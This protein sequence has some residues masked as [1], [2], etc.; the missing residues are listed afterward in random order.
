MIKTLIS[1]YKPIIA[2]VFVSLS[3]TL[4]SNPSAMLFMG[5]FLTLLS[6]LKLMDLNSFAKSFS[7]Y[8]LITKHF[9][10][11]GFIYPFL[12]LFSGLSTIALTNT[13]VSRNT[14]LELIFNQPQIIGFIIFAIGLVGSVSVIKAVYFDKVNFKCACVGGNSKVPLG[15]VSLL[16]N[17]SMAVMGLYL[18]LD[19]QMMI[20]L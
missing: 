5:Y 20:S 18:L 2:L 9:L 14:L 15:F 1:D 3:L 17:L 19:S 11:F 13:S 12:E 7:K 8:D 4:V 6:L 10:V 16:E